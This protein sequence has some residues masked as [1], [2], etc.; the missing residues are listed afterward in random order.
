MIYIIGSGII[1]L[2]IG[3][4]LQKKG[5][6]V[7]IFS[8]SLPGESS[9]AAVGMLA[10]Y[11][12][13]KPGE[14]ELLNLMIESNNLWPGF[15]E[16][17]NSSCKIDVEFQKNS[18]LAIA[19][20]N[21]EM[22]NLK[23]KQKLFKN[24][25]LPFSILDRKQTLNL[26]PN[27]HH[28]I[29]G[30]LKIQNQNQVNPLALKKALLETFK[31]NGGKI[32]QKSKIEKIKL[33]GSKVIIYD[34]IKNYECSK[35]V[36]ASGSWSRK[37]IKDSF[38]ISLPVRPLKGV[39]VEFENIEKKRFFSH[40]L[41]FKDIYIAPRKNGNIV[42]GATEEEDGFNNKILL[43]DIFF[44]IKNLWECLPCSHEYEFKTFRSGLR[45][46]TYDGFPIIGFLKNLDNIICSFGHYRNGILLA[47]VTAQIIL[48]LLNNKGKIK[49]YD[50][51]SPNRFK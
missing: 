7:E 16:Q 11:L 47:P 3:F 26:E 2:T 27:L 18:S 6:E 39:T 46:A 9:E 33:K 5:F 20:T 41:W 1:G 14:V 42:I 49:K 35:L 36:L 48:G 19:N 32:N 15:S 10:P 37:L 24:L 12:E 23:F 44:L 21:D 51:F 17:I 28:N 45:P 38:N 50:F 29:L 31:S 30:S 34:G 13:I 25:K 8:G 40:N 22:E 4:Q 43:R